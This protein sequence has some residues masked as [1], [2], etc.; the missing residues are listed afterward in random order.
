MSDQ[1]TAESP[2]ARPWRQPE[3]LP[4]KTLLASVRD[5][6]DETDSRIDGLP[7]ALAQ[8]R[9]RGDQFRN[10][11]GARTE[12]LTEHGPTRNIEQGRGAAA[13]LRLSPLHTR[14]RRLGLGL[15]GALGDRKDS[16]GSHRL[17]HGR[18]LSVGRQR[19]DISKPAFDL[20]DN[21]G[22]MFTGGG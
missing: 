18:V 21:L 19:A 7:A 8:L 3:P 14:S 12:A 4:K 20:A 2:V 17:R 15:Q 6:V 16:F 11:L 22:H 10:Y 1:Q 9:S 5:A 13:R